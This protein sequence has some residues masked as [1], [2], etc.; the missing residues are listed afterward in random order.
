MDVVKSE[1][2][3]LFSKTCTVIRLIAINES[4]VISM[5]MNNMHKRGQAGR[6]MDR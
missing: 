6:Q 5:I 2:N 4:Y 1:S 3:P